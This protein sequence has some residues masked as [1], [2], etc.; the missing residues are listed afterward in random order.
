MTTAAALLDALFAHASDDER[1]KIRDR[2]P[3][4]DPVIGLRMKTLFDTAKAHA[5]MPLSEVD[6]LFDRPEYEA[7]LSAVCV[8]DF[9][10]RA[11]KLTDDERRALYE[12]YLARHDRINDWGMVDRAAP[13]VVGRYLMDR[14]RD[15]LFTL[16]R[17][18]DVY[19]RRTAITAPLYWTRFGTTKQLADLF[20]LAEELLT[21]TDVLVSKP[22]GIALKHAGVLDE[23]ALTRF[24]DEHA[25]TMQRPTLRYAVEKHPHRA[26]YLR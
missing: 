20:T 12:K 2:H 4:D 14:P 3:H 1:A 18:T 8:L 23:A 7:R 10:A 15:P 9:K 13:H 6:L 17:S 25:A 24:L 26:R 11:K 19:E 22:V 21:D 16:A 5:T